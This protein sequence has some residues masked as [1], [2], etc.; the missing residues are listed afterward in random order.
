MTDFLGLSLGL[1]S[2]P[3]VKGAKEV[4]RATEGI[5]TKVV[6]T[7]STTRR[8]GGSMRDVFKA[9]SGSIQVVQGVDR[10]ADSLSKGAASAS[11]MSAAFLALEIG[12]TADDFGDVARSLTTTTQ[13]VEKSVPILDEFGIVIG[14][15]IAKEAVP[16]ATSGLKTFFQ[17]LAQNPLISLVAGLSLIS[18]VFN[19]IGSSAEKAKDKIQDLK[20]EIRTA[21]T[22]YEVS[23]LLGTAGPGSASELA[24][25]QRERIGKIAEEQY[26]R[27]AN[28]APLSVPDLVSS[29]GPIVSDRRAVE[30][31]V[32][33]MIRTGE[34][35]D[36]DSAGNPIRRTRIF[37][38][39]AKRDIEPQSILDYPDYSQLGPGQRYSYPYFGS[40]D[41]QTRIYGEIAKT[42]GSN[43]DEQEQRMAVQRKAAEE[44]QQRF[45][46][47]LAAANQAM[48]ELR[49][50]G[51]AFG[52]TIGDAFF[53]VAS[54]AQSARD[55]V[56]QIANDLLRSAARS[57]FGQLGSGVFGLF[58]PRTPAFSGGS[59]EQV[60]TGQAMFG[61]QAQWG[62]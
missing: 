46:K 8:F 21:T 56:R 51:E 49:A 34:F 29:L 16:V 50:Q 5:T 25:K 33:A 37:D 10:L 18:G 45:E 62:G 4:E 27:P 12:K 22:S 1:D 55:A 61:T 39:Q 6:E 30:E 57:A 60:Q 28:A 41:E 44:N 7:E 19:L 9:S 11:I 17:V 40:R 14:T 26:N 3:F 36:K 31:A 2:A 48:A 59:A 42:Y 23:K 38:R 52:Q 32:Y 53:N 20:D 43:I 47:Q 15:R 58:G 54:G 35:A 13:I 24:K